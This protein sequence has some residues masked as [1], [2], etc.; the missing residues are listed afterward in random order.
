MVSVSSHDVHFNDKVYE[1]PLEF[2]GFQFSKMI[3]RSESAK[4][5]GMIASSPDHLPFGHGR[6]VC[7]GRH[8]AA[9][10]LK[11]MFAHIIM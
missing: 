11:L 5:V 10:K 2:D 9:C 3:E 8:F 4:K 6:H 7:P 1:D